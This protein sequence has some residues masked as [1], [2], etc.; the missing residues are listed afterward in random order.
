M[1]ELK[2]FVKEEFGSVRVVMRGGE[3]WFIASDVAKALGYERPNDAV[4]THCKKINKFSY[5]DLPQGA[6]PYN[7]IPESD[8]YRL[9][10]RSN[11]P[12][13]VTFQDWVCEEVL[14]S[15]RKTGRVRCSSIAA[16]LPRQNESCGDN[17]RS[18]RYCRQSDGAFFGQALSARDR[19]VRTRSDGYT[20]CGSDQEQVAHTDRDRQGVGWQVC[21]GCQHI[22]SRTWLSETRS[23]HQPMGSDRAR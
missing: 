15:I 13:A 3:P 8:V 22:T 5:G 21:E 23:R 9:V 6:M 7:I 11:L 14:P 16:Q 1:N 4:N 17:P 2:V 18:R 19:A 20:A 10:M 12:N